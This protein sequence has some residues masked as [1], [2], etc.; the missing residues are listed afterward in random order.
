MALQE[1]N[2][3][4]TGNFSNTDSHLLKSYQKVG[5]YEGLERALKMKPTE[6]IEE[7]K[8]SG[9]RGRGGAGFPAGLKWSFVPQ[10]TGKPIY[11]C[12][13]ADESEPGTFKDR[14]ILEL[15]P[16]KVIEGTII[17]SYAI[18]C[19]LAFIYIRG[20]F[21]DGYERLVDA[22]AEAKKANL[23]GKNILG[24]GYSLDILVHRGA[25]AYICGEETGLIESLEGKKGQPRLKPPFPAVVG[26]FQ[27]PTVVNNVETLAAVPYVICHG[28]KGYRKFGT[29][30]SP[31]TKVFSAS[32]FV[33]KPGSYE[34]EL[35]YP[36]AKFLEKELGGMLPGSKMKGL[37]PGGSSTPILKPEE[38]EGL[39][40]DYES[41]ASKGS[42]LGSGGLIVYDESVCIVKASWI[43]SAF[44]AGESCGQCTPCREGTGWS[45]KVLT[46]IYQGKGRTQDLDLLLRMCNGMQGHTIC[47]LADALAMPLRSYLQKFR[48]EFEDYINQKK[49]PAPIPR[50]N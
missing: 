34:I 2:K 40:L 10:N 15:D 19:H 27:C 8:N 24:S 3:I 28:A 4:I 14:D 39:N 48:G 47:V 46:H 32:G 23:L 13:N 36:F 37:I 50:W 38:C 44:Y 7:V 1:T 45:H 18:N 17:A 30:K 25:G 12:V 11:L 29:E 5:G 6:V 16:H 33:N 41:I 22:I 31:G 20:E 42:M 26:A 9:L 35:G 49:M 21:L 43:L